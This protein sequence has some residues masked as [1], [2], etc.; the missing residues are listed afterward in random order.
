M[1][2]YLVVTAA[3]FLISLIGNCARAAT[4]HEEPIA[5]TGTLMAAVVDGILLAWAVGLW[6]SL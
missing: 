5:R 4:V 3:L 1:S 2:A 6:W